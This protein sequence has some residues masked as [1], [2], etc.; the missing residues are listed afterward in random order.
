MVIQGNI[1]PQLTHHRSQEYTE[2]EKGHARSGRVI[3]EVVDVFRDQE[4][5]DGNR[6]GD[7]AG[8]SVHISS[9]SIDS[10]GDYV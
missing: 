8:R 10:H 5:I 6:E 9:S 4:R 3:T 1:V 7:A 2:G